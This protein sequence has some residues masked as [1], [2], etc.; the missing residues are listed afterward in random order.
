[1]V[2]LLD[3]LCPSAQRFGRF[4]P[5]P[6]F[7]EV[8]REPK[9]VILREGLAAEHQHEVLRPGVFDGGNLAIGQ[10][11]RQIDPA[12][13]GPASGRQRRYLDVEHLVHRADP[14]IDALFPNVYH[15]PPGSSGGTPDALAAPIWRR[16]IMAGS[17][18]PGCELVSQDCP[19][20]RE[21]S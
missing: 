12:D 10:R 7:A 1:L 3:P 6:E 9:L 21:R 14:P 8:R 15:D 18:A 13:L 4:L 16:D 20:Q 2:I 17:V 11:P 5:I 19:A